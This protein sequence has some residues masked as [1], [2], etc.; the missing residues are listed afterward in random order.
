MWRSTTN[1]VL[2]GV[3]GGLGERSSINPTLLRWIYGI[4]TIFTGFVPGVIVYVLLWSVT[5]KHHWPWRDQ[6]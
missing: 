4:G 6:W 5:N 2:G 1:S 3:I